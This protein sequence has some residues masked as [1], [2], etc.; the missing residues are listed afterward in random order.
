MGERVEQI[1]QR[2][3]ISFPGLRT[4][5]RFDVTSKASSKYNCIAWA[6]NIDNK[7]MWPNTGKFIFLDG[8]HFW[9]TK[10]IQPATIDSFMKAFQL[11]G[12]ECCDNG[13]FEEG[14]QKIAL[15]AKPSNWNECTH[16]ARQK[17]DGTL[18]K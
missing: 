2:L 3:K 13:E 9:P 11:I 18:D 4:D 6:Y 16:A 1:K 8:V 15:Y 5:K 14:Y 10:E 7:W 12:Y 17:R